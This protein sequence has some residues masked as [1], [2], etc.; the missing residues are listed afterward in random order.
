MEPGFDEEIELFIEDLQKSTTTYHT[1]LASLK[2]DRQELKKCI[3]ELR[4]FPNEDVHRAV[5]FLE[6]SQVKTNK[7]SDTTKELRDQGDVETT[8]EK[9]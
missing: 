3:Q 7:K 8:Q 5:R 9:Q 6:F 2:R 4:N 1:I